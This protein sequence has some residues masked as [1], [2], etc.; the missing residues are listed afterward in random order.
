V[1]SETRI[2]A[3]A[4]KRCCFSDFPLSNLQLKLSDEV[5]DMT[6]LHQTSLQQRLDPRPFRFYPRI[7]STNDTALTWL[8][9]GAPDGAAVIADEQL[10]G[11][12][13]MGRTWHTPPGVA[14]AMSVILKPTHAAL[15]QVTMLGALAIAETLDEMGAQQVGIKWANDVLLNER[16]V[17]GVLSEAAWDEQTHLIGAV[18]GIGLNV[19]VDFT[20]TELAQKAISIEPALGIPLDRADL[21][22][23]LLGRVD[24]WRGQL[25][26]HM[27]FRAWR[28]RLV[29]PGRHV[30]IAQTDGTLEGI[31][32]DVDENGA[33][34][35]RGD[36]GVLHRVVAGDL[37]MG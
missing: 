30:S 36:D 27:L 22:A 23:R 35:V 10:K 25:G 34:L 2:F 28:A 1:E 21:I 24:Y 17:S 13:R 26:T 11:R 3:L 32:Q 29:T 9:D 4:I 18:L 33:L 14:I 37:E 15:P 7:D 20:G 12:G 31:A 6:E 19:R 5:D 8:R 16:K